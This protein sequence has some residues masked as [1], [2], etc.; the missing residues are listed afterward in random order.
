LTNSAPLEAARLDWKGGPLRFST[1]P[2]RQDILHRRTDPIGFEP[3]SSIPKDRDVRR[4]GEISKGE[5]IDER[6]A[7]VIVLD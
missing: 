1:L 7:M 6:S 5:G 4:G 2:F 3:T